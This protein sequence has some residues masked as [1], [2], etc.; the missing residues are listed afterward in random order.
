MQQSKAHVIKSAERNLKT[1][2]TARKA[3]I[4]ARKAEYATYRYGKPQEPFV[5]WRGRV[6]R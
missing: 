1:A 4:A 6:C 3:L 5:D 2:I